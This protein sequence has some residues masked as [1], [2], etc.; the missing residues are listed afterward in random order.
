MKRLIVSTSTSCMDYL[1]KPAN[2]I[3]LPMNVHLDG[4]TYLD[5]RT[6]DDDKLVRFVTENPYS[7][8][9]TSA[10]DEAR[11]IEFFYDL[12]EQGVEEVLVIT[13]S[14]YLSLTYQNIREIRNMFS[15]ILKI[16]V[17][18]SRTVSHGEALLVYAASKML[19]DEHMEIPQIIIRLNKLRDKMKMYITV[20]D[21]TAMIRTKRLSAPAGFFANIF[22]IKPIV[23]FSDEGQVTAYEKVMGFERNLSRLVQLMHNY[24]KGKNGKMYLLVSKHNPYTKRLLEML[25]EVGYHD[26][27][28]TPAASVVMA[29][30]GINA[31]GLLFVENW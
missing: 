21:L 14:S 12:A 2:V 23:V 20:D 29:N 16:H 10:P 4:K 18:D 24:A 26:V 27:V 11:M 13:V 30:I 6:V 28:K 17:L 19:E 31:I 9:T 7:Q 8:P 25:A 3:T 1:E 15:N 5:G 22:G